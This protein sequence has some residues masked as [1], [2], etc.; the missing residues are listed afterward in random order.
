M[1]PAKLLKK[2]SRRASASVGYIIQS[3]TDR[4]LF[5]FIGAGRDIEQPLIRSHVLNDRRCL[6]VHGKHDGAFALLTLFHDD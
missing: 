3:L 1:L 5:I 2:L 4:F 6:P